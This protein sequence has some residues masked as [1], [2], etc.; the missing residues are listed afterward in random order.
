MVHPQ[1]PAASTTSGYTTNTRCSITRLYQHRP[2]VGVQPDLVLFGGLGVDADG[3][4]TSVAEELG[5]GD[6]VGAAPHQRSGEG[7]P[8]DVGGRL[9]V[10]VEPGRRGVNGCQRM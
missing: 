4:E 5:D 10:L 6:Q 2:P 3:L 8:Q 1:P 7:V 9:L